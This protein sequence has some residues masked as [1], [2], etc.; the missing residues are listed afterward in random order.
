[1]RKASLNFLRSSLLRKVA[2]V[3]LVLA[4]QAITG[5]GAGVLNAQ[6]VTGQVTSATDQEPL[7]GASVLVDG[8]SQGGVTDIDGN[9][10]VAAKSGQTLVIS[11]LGFITQKVAVPANGAKL[12]V[13]LQED[14]QS[15]DEVV[16]VG[17]GVQKKKLVTGATLQV[18]GDDVA[19]LNTSNPLQAL[20]GQTPGMTIISQSGQPGEGLKVN[21]RGLGTTGSS[22]PL[23]IIDGV[24]GDIATVNPA[25]IESIDVL[26]D[27]ASAAIYGSQ[28]ANGVVLVTTKN[29]KEGR[30]VVSFDAYYGW[31]SAPRKVDMLNAEQYMT[32]MDEQNVNSGNA[33]YNWDGYKSIWNY[34]ADGNKLGVIDTDWVDAMFKDNAETYSANLSVSGG[35]QKGNYALSMGYMNQEGIV[36]GRD[37]SNYSRY[38]FRVNSEYQ[39]IDN[40][41]KVGEQAS[42]IYYKKNG[43]SVGNAY[44]N[45]LRAAFGTSP[46]S[47][48]Y[49]DNGKYNLPYNDTSDSDWANGDGNPYGA[50][51]TQNSNRTQ[52]VTVTANAF[53]EMEFIK[54]LKFRSTIGVKYDSNNYRSYSPLYHFSIYSY[55]DTRTKASQSASDGFGITWTNTLNYV[56]D[57]KE[58]HFDAMLGY[59]VYR[60]EGQSIYA[61]NGS[62]RDGF[63]TWKYAYLSNGTAT[64]QEQG[65]S[66]SG[67]PWDEERMVSYF[68]RV[69]WNYK[70]TYM[71]TA[72][73]RRDGS[74]RF[75]KGHRF[76]T[77]PSISAG[78]VVTNEKFMEPVLN[79]MDYFKLRASWGQVGNQN[80]GNYMYLAPMTFSN[81]YYNFGTTLGSDADVWGAVPTRLGNDEITWETSEQFDLGFDARLL[82]QRLNVNFDFY[83]KTTK[84]WLVQPPVLA[85]VGTGAPYIN[86]GD[87]KN[88]GVELALSWNDRIGKDFSYHINVNGAYNKNKVGNIPNEDG[89]IHGASGSVLY[90]NSGEFYRASNGE[91]IGYFWGYKTAGIFQNQ[92][93]IDDWIA[94]GNGVLQS[95]PQPGDVK[96]YDVNHDGQINDSDKVNLGDGMPDFNFGFSLG[97]DYKGLD[98][99]MTANAQTGNQIVQTYRNMATTTANYTTKILGRWTGEGTSNTIPR[100]TNTNIN[101]QFSDLF[102]QDGDFLRISNITLGYDFAKLLNCKHIS[103]CRLYAQV[104]NAFTF[105]KY[106]GMDPEIGYGNDGWVSGVD[107]G[108]YPRPRTFLFGVNLKF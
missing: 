4:I 103:Q 62:L 43:I 58:H 40:F 68:G 35:N 97:F 89:I 80:I 78:W 42:F 63:D 41:L 106:D 17:Y 61:A 108:Y 90:D 10:S 60:T 12:N 3:A 101:Y 46:L 88:T 84:D 85:T 5:I 66:V 22:G 18:K 79:V 51:M 95:S 8:T 83:I 32:I 19:R 39:V 48:I 55:N 74:S 92:Q 70:E 47:P 45:T 37:V 27:A 36:G 31:Q 6:N 86:G 21:I 100:V 11:Y 16:V 52:N 65:L 13:V 23:Y 34:D 49:S 25:D 50:M 82:N 99:S 94:A 30:S 77:F 28:S 91:P 29:G 54:N 81:H 1:M 56:F 75:A 20:Q 76:G 105:T 24:R 102:I 104:Q 38:N 2:L 71:A 33:A 26:K 69:G 53:A 73:V 44:N 57:V 15:L 59:E 64:N 14:R 96:Y 7:I 98:F 107:Y 72:T 67:A 87:V 9:F 93:E